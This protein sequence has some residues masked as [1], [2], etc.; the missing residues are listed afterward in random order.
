MIITH[1]RGV[2]QAGSAPGLGPGG[3]GVRDLS[4]PTIEI[5]YAKKCI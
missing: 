5:N 3:P 2:A 4:A 1:Q